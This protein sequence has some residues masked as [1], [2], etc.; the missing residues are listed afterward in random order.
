[1]IDYFPLS[2]L[3]KTN[4]LTSANLA[5]NEVELSDSRLQNPFKPQSDYKT[6][7]FTID[8]S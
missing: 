7:F 6:S 2:Q 3:Y 8:T 1:M 5:L 4:T